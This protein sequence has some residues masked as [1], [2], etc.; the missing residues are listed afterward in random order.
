MDK[1]EYATQKRQSLRPASLFRVIGLVRINK[2]VKEIKKNENAV[3]VW[4]SGEAR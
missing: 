3:I 1:Q 2:Q 4:L